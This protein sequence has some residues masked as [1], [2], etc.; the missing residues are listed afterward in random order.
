M[1]QTGNKRTFKKGEV[2][3]RQGDYEIFMYEILKGCVNIYTDY[4][5][6]SQKKLTTLIEGDTFGEMGLIN[7]M[8]RSATAI[9]A[10]ETVAV[11]IDN[12]DFGAYFQDRP[13][14]VLNI[15]SHLSS[16]MRDLT[17][18][19]MEACR[20]IEE[21]LEAEKKNEPKSQ[22]LIDRMKKFV[23]VSRKNRRK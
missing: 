3:F 12:R 20:T 8:P 6:D 14:E 19:Y 5:E 4:G 21:Y 18:D 11:L 16:R 17:R 22:N 7:S 9:A 2:I 15:F 1:K 23:K 10:E 13:S